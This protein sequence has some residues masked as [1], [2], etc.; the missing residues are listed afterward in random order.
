MPSEARNLT[1]QFFSEQGLDRWEN[2]F[3]IPSHLSSYANG[4]KQQLMEFPFVST[5]VD[6]PWKQLWPYLGL[7]RRVLASVVEDL[8][9]RGPTW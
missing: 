2:V 9:L 5:E 8:S 4:H 1:G 7:L 6:G 3:S